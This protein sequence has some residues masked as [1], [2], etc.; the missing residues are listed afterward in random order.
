VLGAHELEVGK[1]YYLIVSNMSGL[2]RYDINDVIEV[3]GYYNQ[4]PLFRFLRK[5]AGFTSLTGEKITETQVLEAMGRA[6]EAEGVDVR[7][8]NLVCDEESLS[9]RLFL[10]V[11]QSAGEGAGERILRALDRK[12]AEIN[13]EYECKR[14]SERLAA[15]ILRELPAG[16]Y[17]LVKDALIARGMA[18]E[19]QYK[20]IYLERKPEVLAVYEEIAAQRSF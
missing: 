17:E 11:D 8:F 16:S 2:Y 4:I 7:H 10:E 12:L 15:P 20:S 19:G 5:G 14:G 6:Q 3:V 13:P 18:R 9:Y 1:R